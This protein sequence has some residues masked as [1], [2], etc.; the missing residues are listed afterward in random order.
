[1]II[2]TEVKPEN[3]FATIKKAE[4]TI[5]FQPLGKLVT[6]FAYAN[7]KININITKL[8]DEV[9]SL[10]LAAKILEEETKTIGDGTSANLI[11]SMTM[12]IKQSCIDNSQRLREIGE[13]FGC[14]EIETPE[15]IHKPEEKR[16][17]LLR[18][19]KRQ[20]ITLA[21]IAVTSIVSI[22]TATQLI[23]IASGDDNEEVAIQSNHIV[24]ALQ[25][26]SNRI[27]RNEA[28]IK[29]LTDHIEKLKYELVI[30]RK[31][32]AVVIRSLGLKTEAIGITNHLQEIQLGLFEILKGNLSPHIVE[33]SVIQKALNVLHRKV[34]QYGYILSTNKAQEAFQGMTSFVSYKNGKLVVLLHVPIYKTQSTL[35]AYKYV[36]TPIVTTNNETTLIINPEKKILAVNI[37]SELY[38]ETTQ[39]YLEHS[40]RK[41]KDIYFCK[42]GAIL[43][44]RNHESCLRNLYTKN[45][46]GILKQCD[47]DIFKEEEFITKLNSTSF[48]V[49]TKKKSLINLICI[50]EGTVVL[51]RKEYISNTNIINLK[52]SCKANL[53][54][55][56]ISHHIAIDLEMDY[57]F[58]SIGVNLTE[59]LELNK[60]QTEKF[61]EFAEKKLDNN[62]AGIRLIK[63]REKFHLHEISQHR[64]FLQKIKSIVLA[65]VSALCLIILLYIIVKLSLNLVNRK[66]GNKKE[67]RINVNL[68]NTERKEDSDFPEGQEDDQIS[69]TS[70]Y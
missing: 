48:L 51:D 30:A 35:F 68:K 70:K 38:I 26:T 67:V 50:K 36:S 52:K 58:N 34:S 66:K 57:Q 33:M 45:M 61:I 6:Q 27:S 65:I 47:L 22:Y 56:I 62:N 39:Y 64:G 14:T 37:E 15:H 8:Y 41:I 19:P 24:T 31:K 32:D 10:C 44:R 49:Y 17:T 29:Q 1:M 18:R 46:K 42:D 54:K 3:D 43:K 7:I 4:P 20:L 59:I 5:T 60:E 28:K 12:D 21:V 40:C 25:D 53:Q 55:H 9:N 69:L 13:T 11:K 63:I 23:D 16:E 2:I